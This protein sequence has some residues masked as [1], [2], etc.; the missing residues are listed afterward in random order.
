MSDYLNYCSRR[1][2]LAA[3]G[4]GI[5]AV[6]L[7]AL[8][9]SD[10]RSATLGPAHVDLANPLKVRPPHLPARAKNVIFLFQYGG[11]SQVDTFDYKPELARLADQPVPAAIKAIKDKVGGVFGTSNDKIMAPEVKFAQHGQSGLW[12]SDLF[13]NLVRHVDDLCV[14]R[15]M[16]C[17]SSN[18][19]PATYQMNTGAILGGKPSFG[20]WL[21][22]GLGSENQNLPGYVLLFKVA[23]LGG[24]ANWSNAFLPAAFQG[25]PFRQEGAPV[26]NLT[27][28]GPL[29]GTQRSTLDA[30]QALNRRH[31]AAGRE[32]ADLEGRIA[33][34]EL[35]YRMQSEALDVGDFADESAATLDMYGINDGNKDQA[36][37]ARQCLLARRLVER[38]VRVVQTYH[39]ADK[40]G[41]DGHVG[42]AE[43]HRVQA[44]S[45]DKPIAALLT[46]L[47]QRGLL[48]TTLIVWAGE[49]GRTPME[50]GD[51]GRNHNPYGFTV[52]LAGGGVQGG[53]AIGST[54]EI[55]LRAADDPHPVKDLHATLLH[56]L[57]LRHDDL[58]FEHNG[59]PER[60]TG[61]AGSAKVI[62]KVFG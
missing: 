52:W 33:T 1:S 8:L 31:A 48:D 38:G 34:Y 57:G 42:N 15:S 4:G 37:C 2:F 5:G 22:Y 60:L 59:R 26:L 18:H 29:A 3:T 13:P 16:T 53:Q 27:P 17:E 39:S 51:R 32:A 14:I 25:T 11:P 20:S 55:G 41:W 45:T 56:G 19:A 62:S 44:A 47:K 36:M 46:D 24:S 40:L 21:T 6:A 43:N 28:P 50:Q 49:F 30:I 12:I 23:G 61:V 7:T 58:Y 10:S 54:D 9:A 35:A